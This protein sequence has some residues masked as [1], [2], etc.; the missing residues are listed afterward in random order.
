MRL[1]QK[2][3]QPK[4]MNEKIT[5]SERFREGDLLLAINQF[6]NL[7]PPKY[8]QIGDIVKNIELLSFFT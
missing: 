1:P 3:I 2:K 6:N 8:C 7:T 5:L 4:A